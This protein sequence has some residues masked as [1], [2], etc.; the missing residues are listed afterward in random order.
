MKTLPNW[1][2]TYLHRLGL[3]QEAASLSYLSALCRAHL[4]TFPYENVSKLLSYYSYKTNSVPT[5]SAYIENAILHDFG[6]TCYASNASFLALLRE[7]GFSGYLI[8]LADEHAAIIITELLD[9]ADL[10]YV[11]TAAAAPFFQPVPFTSDPLYLSSFG[12][13]SAQIAPDP[14]HPRRYRFRRMRHQELVN[15]SWYFDPIQKRELADLAPAIARSFQPDATFLTCLRLHLYQL[16]QNRCLSLKN[17]SLFILYENGEDQNLHLRS[18]DELESIVAS[19][20]GL[21]RLPVREAVSALAAA[22]I[23]V[24]ADKS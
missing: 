7:L 17:N 11:D 24:F 14:A 13:E 1:A 19:E 16:S 6:G 5:P 10:L 23:D 20:F 3:K 15:D 8:S 12:Y 21:P 22:G 9:S 4:Q 18:I 2:N